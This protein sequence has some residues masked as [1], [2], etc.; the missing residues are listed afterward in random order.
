MQLTRQPGTTAR[1]NVPEAAFSRWDCLVV[2]LVFALLGAIALPMLASSPGSAAQ[3]VCGNNLRILTRA[4]LLWA[5]DNQ[6]RFNWMVPYP[7]GGSLGK[8]LAREHFQVL[9]NFLPDPKILVCPAGKETP[10]SNFA[11]LKRDGLS[12]LF[13][14]HAEPNLP[15]EFLAG[16][17]N[18]A[19]TDT[20]TCGRV[21]PPAVV[22]RA[23]GS[24]LKPNT[25][26]IAWDRGYHNMMGHLALSDGSVR[27]GSSGALR[28]MV[29]RTLTLDL[30]SAHFL[31]P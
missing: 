25:L 13:G 9:S 22:L 17:P 5:L 14:P 24:P 6:D 2:G 12:Y 4:A 11:T 21:G 8:T 29:S 27:F 15:H 30:P 7:E 26:S 20:A 28:L 3:A 18:L 19:G 31:S 10:G 16:D 1:L 23:Q